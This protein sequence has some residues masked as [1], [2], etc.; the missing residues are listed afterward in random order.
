MPIP[1]SHDSSREYFRDPRKVRL[2]NRNELPASPRLSPES[3]KD[4]RFGG[5]ERIWSELVTQG[6]AKGD[7]GPKLLPS[8]VLGYLLR[9][10][11]GSQNEA[12]GFLPLHFL[13]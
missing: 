7:G 8:L 1:V 13:E 6:C 2:A 11:Q 5:E 4:R 12:A 10:L 3:P 9:P